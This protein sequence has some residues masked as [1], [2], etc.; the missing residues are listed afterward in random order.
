MPTANVFAVSKKVKIL[1]PIE[2]GS[3][4]TSRKR[5]LELVR[6]NRAIFVDGDSQLRLIEGDPRNQAAALRAAEGYVLNGELTEA[7]I[8]HIPLERP[9]KALRE[10]NTDRSRSGR[11]PRGRSGRVRIIV[12]AGV[13]EKSN[14]IPLVLGRIADVDTKPPAQSKIGTPTTTACEQSYRPGNGSEQ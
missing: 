6:S 9:A 13:K 7:E 5:A 1:N 8:K 4:I 10:A 3:N 12:S 2:N 14:R 11:F